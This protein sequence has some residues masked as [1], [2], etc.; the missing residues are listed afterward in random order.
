MVHARGGKEVSAGFGFKLV[1][2][3]VDRKRNGVWII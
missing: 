1:Y 2:R 3:G